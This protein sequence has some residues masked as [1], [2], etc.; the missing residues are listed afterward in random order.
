MKMNQFYFITVI[1]IL[2]LF[3]ILGNA[4]EN[5]KEVKEN[6][7]HGYLFDLYQKTREQIQKENKQKPLVLINPEILKLITKFLNVKSITRCFCICRDLNENIKK[8]SNRYTMTENVD[9]NFLFVK[10]LIDILNINEQKWEKLEDMCEL[11][12]PNYI[13]LAW[14]NKNVSQNIFVM[15]KEYIEKMLIEHFISGEM[16][17]E[18]IARFKDLFEQFDPT[19]PNCSIEYQTNDFVYT[20]LLFN[21][22][23][24]TQVINWDESTEGKLEIASLTYGFSFFD[25]K[26]VATPHEKNL[27][28]GFYMRN[29]NV[30]IR[31]NDV[32]NVLHV[33]EQLRGILENEHF[34]GR[35]TEEE[36]DKFPVKNITEDELVKM[37]HFENYKSWSAREQDVCGFYGIKFCDKEFGIF[38]SQDDEEANAEV[39]NVDLVEENL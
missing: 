25:G 3:P 28:I 7:V 30:I 22:L 23:S 8:F 10:P 38:S 29:K 15:T 34:N 17:E 27:T 14:R 19:S 4:M 1:A 12:L 18:G 16:A 33:N 24:I 5:D 2:I 6:E 31:D 35:I 13:V 32:L 26:L 37:M 39:E 21:N 20:E 36:F 11:Y 9:L